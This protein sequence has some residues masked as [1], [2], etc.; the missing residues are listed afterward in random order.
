MVAA[1]TSSPEEVEM[2]GRVRTG[3]LGI[4]TVVAGALVVAMIGGGVATAATPARGG[5]KPTRIR[6]ES[7]KK[8]LYFRGPATIKRG[9]DLQIVNHTNPKK[10]GPH[11]FSIVKRKFVPSSK[12]QIRHCFDR[13]I[14]ASIA[15][16]HEFDEKTGKV[17]RRTVEVGSTGWD[18][19]FTDKHFGDSWYTEAKKNRQTRKVTAKP[20]TKLFYICAVH[21]FMQGKITVVK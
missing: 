14:C 8:D 4:A 15:A 19:G 7:S 6:M 1:V 21:P 13:G 16:A 3:R 17:N 5:K 18:K 10:V 20:G 2:R 12:K 9:T 11:T